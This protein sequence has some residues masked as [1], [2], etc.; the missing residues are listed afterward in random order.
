MTLCSCGQYKV[1]SVKDNP[2]VPVA[3]GVLY[4]LPRTQLCIAVTVERRDFSRAPYRAF[5]VDYV[6]ADAA[7]M[8]TSYRLVGIDVSGVNV[9][10]P[11]YYYFVKVNRGSVTVDDRHLLLAIGMD[12][13]ERN[14]SEP[15]PATNKTTATLPRNVGYNLYDRTDTLYSRYDKPGRPTMVST[16]K[17]V[18]DARRRAADAA[19]RLEEVQGKMRELINGEYE[20]TYGAESVKY[21][22][23]QLKREESELIALFCGEVCRETVLFY[24]DPLL[25]RKDEYIDT[26]IWFSSAAGFAGDE[27]H[28]PQDAFPVVCSIRTDNTMRSVNRFVKYHTSGITSNSSSGHTGRAASRFRSRHNFRYRIPEKVAVEITTPQ[29]CVSRQ[30]PMSQM[31][32]TVELPRRRV[33]ALF[34]AETLDLKALK[35]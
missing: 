20:G 14:E 25:K 24:V 11:D 23:D 21:L 2:A 35:R 16:R 34:D 8:D 27:E 1:Y 13:D 6:G 3:G 22:Y 26:I 19:E 7:D 4:A 12:A 28:L 15:T 33:K 31:G 9:A 30:V 17:D 10:D 29:Y 5:A 18:R 32:P